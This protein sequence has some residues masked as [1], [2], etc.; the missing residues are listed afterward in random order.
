LRNPGVIQEKFMV[1]VKSV[2]QDAF[3]TP[4]TKIQST[5]IFVKFSIEQSEQKPQPPTTSD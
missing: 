2:E 4:K 1:E 3:G 5:I